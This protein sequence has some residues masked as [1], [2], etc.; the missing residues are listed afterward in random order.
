MINLLAAHPNVAIVLSTSWVRFRSFGYAKRRLAPSL[1]ER[2]VGAP[3]HHRMMRSDEF[4]KL[5]RGMQIWGD[6]QRREPLDWFAIDD[7]PFGWPAWCREK[8]IR[9]DEK[10]GLSDTAIQNEIRDRL[11]RW[12]V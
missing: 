10:L 2:A 6:V 5:P 9:T 11:G 4:G 1:Q 12:P 7:D 8:L 3:F